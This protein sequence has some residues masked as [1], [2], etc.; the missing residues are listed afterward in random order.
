M[1]Q[2]ALDAARDLVGGVVD[3][4]DDVDGRVAVRPAP[5]PVAPATE[6][7]TV[8]PP[9]FYLAAPPPALRSASESMW[10][11]SPSIAGWFNCSVG[12]RKMPS[13]TAVLAV[14]TYSRLDVGH[15][16]V[17]DGIERLQLGRL[18]PVEPD[19]VVAGCTRAR[20][21]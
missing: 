3:G 19:D 17:L 20:V 5:D 9:G 21:R 14:L 18:A 8:V 7:R 1:E 6:G 4:N 2:H 13:S 12:S 16:L 11:A 15:E 10:V